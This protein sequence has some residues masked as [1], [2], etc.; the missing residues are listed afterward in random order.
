LEIYGETIAKGNFDQ[1]VFITAVN[2]DYQ[3]SKNLSFESGIGFGIS[4]AS[5]DY[6]IN[7]KL[8]FTF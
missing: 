4:R 7:S 8:T 1:N 2:L 3:L 6:Q 5:P